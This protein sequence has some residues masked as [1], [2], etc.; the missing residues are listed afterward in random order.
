MKKVRDYVQVSTQATSVVVYRTN[1]PTRV[2]VDVS[3][4]TYG[5]L[6]LVGGGKICNQPMEAPYWFTKAASTTIPMTRTSEPRGRTR[7][8]SKHTNSKRPAASEDRYALKNAGTIVTKG[9]AILSNGGAL[10]TPPV[11]P[12]SLDLAEDRRPKI[13]TNVRS[14]FQKS[15]ETSVSD[16]TSAAEQFNSYR[17]DETSVLRTYKK[18]MTLHLKDQMFRKL[19]FIT[20]D[21]MLA[22]SRQPKSICSYVCTQMRVSSY[23]WGDYWDLVKKAT[24]K[25]I[26]NQRTNATS[27]VKK[28]F[29][30]K[31]N[32]Q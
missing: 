2:Y 28:G 8:S 23:Q 9:L 25:M 22:F 32:I 10:N 14:N 17:F 18:M 6:R 13:A 11:P 7:L 26:E 20:N 21:E 4:Q 5:V 16:I 12:A 3:V 29:K 27:A 19:K 31:Y 15:N 30:R 1:N 24:K